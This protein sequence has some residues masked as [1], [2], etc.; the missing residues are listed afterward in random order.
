MIWLVLLV[1]VVFTAWSI[2]YGD[3]LC[4]ES[5]IRGREL[6]ERLNRKKGGD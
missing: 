6:E 1:I 3:A 5:N 2:G 4:D